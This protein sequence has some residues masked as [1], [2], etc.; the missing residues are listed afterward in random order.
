MIHF[1]C[2]GS[3]QCGVSLSLTDDLADCVID[4]PHSCETI[5]VPTRSFVESDW[6]A[7]TDP[8]AM[9]LGLPP[10]ASDR[11]LRSFALACCRRIEPRLTHRLSQQALVL[12]DRYCDGLATDKDMRQLAHRFCDE[13]NA[14]QAA[15]GGYRDTKDSPDLDAAYFM[16]LQVFPASAACYAMLTAP[17]P[18]AEWIVQCQLLRCILGNPFQPPPPRPEAIAPLA[19]RIYAGEWKLMPLLGEWLQEHGFWSEGEHCLDPNIPHVKGCWVVDWVT[20]RE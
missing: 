9:L 1:R 20:G 17:D 7:S 10:T 18:A 6:L 13:Y 16:T 3:C 2:P 8:Q 12:A 4:C 5:R 15:T 19:E 11:R 14:R